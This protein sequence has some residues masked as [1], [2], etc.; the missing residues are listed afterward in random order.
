MQQ[1]ICSNGHRFVAEVP[2]SICPMGCGSRMITPLADVRP[3]TPAGTQAPPYYYPPPVRRPVV[4]AE[5]YPKLTTTGKGTFVAYSVLYWLS[6]ALMNLGLLLL[7]VCLVALASEAE[8]EIAGLIP[9]GMI[10]LAIGAPLAI[11]AAI[12]G[13]ILLYRGWVVVQDLRSYADAPSV[14]SPGAAVGFCFIPYFNLYWMF[15][16]YAGLAN[17]LNRYIQLRRLRVRPAKPGLA[18]AACIFFFLA[19]V[20]PLN[21]ASAV[22]AFAMMCNLHRVT[23]DIVLAG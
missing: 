3:A 22:L 16:A 11:A 15:V 18:I 12:F 17:R 10:F 1:F 4:T 9:V 7:L 5:H 20:P 23:R 6:F 21:V 8:E 19:A 2:P 14:P 13:L